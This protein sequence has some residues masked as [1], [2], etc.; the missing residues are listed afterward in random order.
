V[1]ALE[2]SN[3]GLTY[4]RATTAHDLLASS[5]AACPRCSSPLALAVPQRDASE[6]HDAAVRQSVA[7]AED[8]A[9]RGDYA[10][11][12]AWLATVEAIGDELSQALAARRRGW[13]VR[14]QSARVHAGHPAS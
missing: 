4:G 6:R 14:M 11:A 7:W 1:P 8:A 12:L 3:C 13:S 10:G 9:R 5:G 2:C